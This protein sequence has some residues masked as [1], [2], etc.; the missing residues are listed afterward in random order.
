MYHLN[1]MDL[2]HQR[3]EDLTREARSN[4]LAKQLRAARPKRA[5]WL[6]NALF[7]QVRAVGNL[8]VEDSRCA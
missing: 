6:R 2:W 4:H 5:A 7:G 8:R 1:E 3:H